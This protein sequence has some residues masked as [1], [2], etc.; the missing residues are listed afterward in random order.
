MNIED[1][2]K[3]IVGAILESISKSSWDNV[4]SKTKILE[5][6]TETSYWRKKDQELFENENFPSVK[7]EVAASKAIISLRDNLLATTGQRIWGL[8]FTL[9]PDGKFNIEYDYNKPADYE[10]TDALITG[11]EIN[12]ILTNL[13]NQK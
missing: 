8:T 4:G 3:K 5:S 6:M 2:Y 13:S 12:Q 10:E 1:N 9:Y 11:E 7:T